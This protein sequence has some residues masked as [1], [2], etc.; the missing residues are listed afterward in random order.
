MAI[1]M[2]PETRVT[3][4]ATEGRVFST[5]RAR[6]PAAMRP[7]ASPAGQPL[8]RRIGSALIDSAATLARG[9][10]RDDP[11]ANERF[12]LARLQLMI[13]VPALRARHLD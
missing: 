13:E 7:A 3:A 11:T 4:R 1:I 10:D 9:G 6:T 5:V 8:V 2:A 12:L